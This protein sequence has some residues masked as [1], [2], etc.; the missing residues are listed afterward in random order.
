[1]SRPSLTEAEVAAVR[2][3]F[4]SGWLGEGP[5]VKAFES[6]L[7]EYTGVRHVVAVNTGTSALHVA[8]ESLGVGRGHEVILPSFTFAADAMAIRLCGATPVFADIDPATL[9][10]DPADVRKRLTPRTRAVMPTDYGGLPADVPGIRRALG[11]A[12]VRIVRDAAHSFGS[13]SDGRPVGL[14]HGEDATCFSFDA[15]KTL[16]CGEGG[17]VLVDGDDLARRLRRKRTLGFEAGARPRSPGSAVLVRGVVDTGYRYHMS[18]IN[19]AIGIVQLGR[20]AGIAERKR[21]VA[22]L[23]DRLLAGQPSIGT[24]PR[25]YD[26]VVPFIYPVRVPADRRDALIER[27][28]SRGIHADLRYSPCHLDPLFSDGATHLPVTEALTREVLCLPIYADL[29]ADEVEEVTEVLKEH[30]AA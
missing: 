12:A 26:E 5:R 6:A 16:T 15:I 10:L 9:N 11:G 23:Y 1:M 29:G 14:H 28:A 8:L 24:F 4:E 21:N 20:F 13:L 22:K 18:D 17:A 7:S 30:L 25:N 19:A 27:F 3:V 2:E